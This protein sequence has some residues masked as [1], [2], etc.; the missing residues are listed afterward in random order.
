MFAHLRPAVSL[1][2]VMTLITGVAY[3]LL[4]SGVAQGLMPCPANGSLIE[5]GGK[6]R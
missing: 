3:P 6:R 4:V 5:P 2:V 1:L